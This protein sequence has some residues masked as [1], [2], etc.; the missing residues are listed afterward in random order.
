M[1]TALS[2]VA[3]TYYTVDNGSPLTY[4]GTAFFVSGQGT[5]ALTYWSMDTAGNIETHTP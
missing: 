4:A 5:H 2:G 3:A 1:Q